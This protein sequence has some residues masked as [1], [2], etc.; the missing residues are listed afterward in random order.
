MQINIASCSICI[1]RHV[2]NSMRCVTRIIDKEP[3]MH[4]YEQVYIG[5]AAECMQFSEQESEYK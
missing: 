4:G 5:M 2:C 1:H 3:H